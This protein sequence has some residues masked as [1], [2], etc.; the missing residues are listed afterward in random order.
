MMGKLMDKAKG[1]EAAVQLA[2]SSPVLVLFILMAFGFLYSQERRESQWRQFLDG[3]NSIWREMLTEEKATQQLRIAECHAV[4]S[5]ATKAIEKVADAL[6]SQATAF[7]RLSYRLQ[8]NREIE[9][10]RFE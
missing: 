3:Q 10:P 5:E 2:K 1:S 9:S 8:Y 4:Q 7:D 6:L